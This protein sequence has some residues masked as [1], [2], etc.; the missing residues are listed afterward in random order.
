MTRVADSCSPST[1]NLSLVDLRCFH[2]RE[3]AAAGSSILVS[4]ACPRAQSKQGTSVRGRCC[5]FL[6]AT[7]WFFSRLLACTSLAF[8]SL[9]LPLWV[10]SSLGRE[11]PGAQRTSSTNSDSGPASLKAIRKISKLSKILSES[12]FPMVKWLPP[13][14]IDPVYGVDERMDVHTLQSAKTSP[15]TAHRE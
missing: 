8:I 6:P 5:F 11:R 9:L 10:T 14:E 3:H 12:R 15:V 13:I 4:M 2:L 7:I 1:F